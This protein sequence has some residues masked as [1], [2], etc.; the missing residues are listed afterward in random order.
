MSLAV[1]LV[2]GGWMDGGWMVV[3]GGGWW[4]WMVVDRRLEVGRIS[5]DRTFIM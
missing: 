2:E 4:W 5:H 1:G 3:D